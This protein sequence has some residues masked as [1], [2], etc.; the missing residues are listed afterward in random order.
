MG[1]TVPGFVENFLNHVH[2]ATKGFSIA[3]PFVSA[4]LAAHF[5]YENV[6]WLHDHIERHQNLGFVTAAILAD[7]AVWRWRSIRGGKGFGVTRPYLTLMLHGLAIPGFT[8][9]L[10][11]NLKLEWGIEV[12]GI[13]R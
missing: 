5:A 13:A 3:L 12:R 6:E 2:V 7:L 8:G 1:V 9:F 4:G 11:S 10:G